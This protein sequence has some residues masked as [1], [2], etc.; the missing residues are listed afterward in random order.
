LFRAVG[1]RFLKTSVKDAI[2]QHRWVRHITG[3]HTTPVLYEYLDL[4]EKLESVQLRPLEGDCFVWCWTLDGIYLA[5]S[6][7]RSFFLAMSFLL[8]AREVWKA[9]APPKVKFFF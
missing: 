4:W 3:A 5:S 9:S 2:F 1:R 8:G 6:A 7:Y